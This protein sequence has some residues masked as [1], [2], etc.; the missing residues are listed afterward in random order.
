MGRSRYLPRTQNSS[1]A[2]IKSRGGQIIQVTCAL[3]RNKRS[4]DEIPPTPGR[5]SSSMTGSLGVSE[6][7]ASQYQ[8][9]LQAAMS[10]TSEGL[11]VYITSRARGRLFTNASCLLSTLSISHCL[12]ARQ[13]TATE[14]LNLQV[15]GLP[16]VP[17]KCSSCALNSLFSFA[18]TGTEKSREENKHG[19]R[20]LT[21]LG[22]VLEN[23]GC[24]KINTGGHTH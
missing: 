20:C 2:K 21:V 24:R 17:G 7:W 3:M 22:L 15:R 10:Q 14:Q 23:L 5:S 1:V 13:Y 4:M 9:A 16:G 18:N 12:S 19:G 11:K 8:M 6:L